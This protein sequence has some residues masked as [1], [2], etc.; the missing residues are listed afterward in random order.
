MEWG[1]TVFLTTSDVK[2][3]VKWY[4]TNGVLHTLGTMP[5]F[6]FKF[7]IENRE[8]TKITATKAGETLTN[9]YINEEDGYLYINLPKNTFSA[10]RLCVSSEPVFTDTTFIDETFEP[11][12]G[13]VTRYLYI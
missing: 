12:A 1:D 13:K 7:W 4:D 8:S 5:D 11:S 2:V 3:R 6:T 9:C 10:G